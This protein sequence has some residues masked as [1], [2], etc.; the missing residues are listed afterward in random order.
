M[1]SGVELNR[2]DGVSVP[3][4]DIH[5]SELVMLGNTERESAASEDDDDL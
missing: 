1:E 2:D 4:V 5:V 3:T